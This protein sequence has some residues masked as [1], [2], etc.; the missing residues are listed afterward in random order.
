M[1]GTQLKAPH[2]SEFALSPCL[3]SQISC[4]Y[5]ATVNFH[6]LRCTPFVVTRAITFHLS[7]DNRHAESPAGLLECAV[8]NHQ[9]QEPI[10]VR[11]GMTLPTACRSRSCLWIR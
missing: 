10:A 3:R 8:L 5:H 7:A 6:P 9:Y 11:E 1:S 2:A 4:A